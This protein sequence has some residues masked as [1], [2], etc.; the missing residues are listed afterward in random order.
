MIIQIRNIEFKDKKY[1]K[2]QI[3]LFESYGL[4]SK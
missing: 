4:D 3:E 1:S 2:L